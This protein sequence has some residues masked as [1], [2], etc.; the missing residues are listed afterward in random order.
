MV[1]WLM[2]DESKKILNEA[3]VT[4]FEV[5]SWYLFGGGTEKKPRNPQ[6]G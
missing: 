5:L 1:G 3:F 6:L 4:Y 2:N